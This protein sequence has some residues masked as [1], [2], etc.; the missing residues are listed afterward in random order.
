MNKVIETKIIEITNYIEGMNPDFKLSD[1]CKYFIRLE[2][3]SMHSHGAC[4]ALNQLDK[5]K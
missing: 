2:L 1:E 4:D 3:D 5:F